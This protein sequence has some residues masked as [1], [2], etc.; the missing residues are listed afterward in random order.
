MRKEHEQNLGKDLSSV[1]W[2]CKG[3]GTEVAGTVKR[4][5]QDSKS[6]G[7]G[8]DGSCGARRCEGEETDRLGYSEQKQPRD[9]LKM[10]RFLRLQ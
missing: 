7:R 3:H 2:E 5:G 4:Q 6:S 9:T 8:T 10:S 1:C